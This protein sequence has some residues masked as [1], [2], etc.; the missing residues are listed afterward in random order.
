MG[1]SL[2]SVTE[3][4]H[5]LIS[6][7]VTKRINSHRNSSIDEH[8]EINQRW[9]QRNVRQSSIINLDEIKSNQEILNLLEELTKRVRDNELNEGNN[10][11]RTKIESLKI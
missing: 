5:F 3:I 1:C 7:F 10:L 6:S 11:R 8:D 2:L 9:A 4:F